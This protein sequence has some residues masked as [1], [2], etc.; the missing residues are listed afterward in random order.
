MNESTF[1]ARKDAQGLPCASHYALGKKK[2]II[3]ADEPS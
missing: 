3:M 2:A 1:F